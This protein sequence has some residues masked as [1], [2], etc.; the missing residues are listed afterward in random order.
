VILNSTATIHHQ[1]LKKHLHWHNA[2]ATSIGAQAI[3]FNDIANLDAYGRL[4]NGY[5]AVDSRGLCPSGW[6]VPTDGEFMML[7]MELGMS[8]SATVRTLWVLE[9]QLEDLFKRWPVLNRYW[10]PRLSVMRRQIVAEGLVL[11]VRM[12]ND[13]VMK[14]DQ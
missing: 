10:F 9:F 4:Y 11:D 1:I 2:N 12:K 5:T 13:E 14:G 7:E 3:L 8:E 6:N